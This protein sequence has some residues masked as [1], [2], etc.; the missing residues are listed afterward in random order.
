MVTHLLFRS[1]TNTYFRE[2]YTISSD[3]FHNFNKNTMGREYDYN[4]KLTV[5]T[6]ITLSQKSLTHTH[7]HTTCTVHASVLA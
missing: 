2:T 4:H 1:L 3:V 6:T 5:F 7:T